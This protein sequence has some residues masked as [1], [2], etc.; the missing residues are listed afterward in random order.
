MSEENVL[1]ENVEEALYKLAFGDQYTPRE[2]EIFDELGRHY[3]SGDVLV[4]EADG[5][6]KLFLI[7]KGSVKVVKNYGAEDE[8]GIAVLTEGEIFG[9]M[10]YFDNMPRSAS[11]VAAGDA[12]LLVLG[13][14]HFDM[15]FQIHPKWT[16]KIM[17]ALAQ[18]IYLA[19]VD[20]KVNASEMMTF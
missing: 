4:K 16:N 8:K 18:R 10:T 20:I 2:K 7:V 14:E 12:D 17:K 19:Y 15:L 6:N 1:N 13:K 11:V 5:D 3:K 9:E